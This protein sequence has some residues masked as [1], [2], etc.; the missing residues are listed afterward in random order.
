MITHE[1]EHGLAR[2]EAN[3]EL[4]GA[5]ALSAA[6]ECGEHCEAAPN[7]VKMTPTT[8]KRPAVFRH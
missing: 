1:E 7:Q 3:K 5:V 6:D 4:H 8:R 2:D